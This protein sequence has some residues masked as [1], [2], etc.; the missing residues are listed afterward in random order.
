MRTNGGIGSP[1][2]RDGILRGSA[3]GNR[4]LSHLLRGG[5]APACGSIGKVRMNISR[6]KVLIVGDDPWGLPSVETKPSRSS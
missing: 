1:G 3:E 6:T 4:D 2:P 5:Q